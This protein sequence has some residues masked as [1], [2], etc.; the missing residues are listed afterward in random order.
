MERNFLR[1]G[2]ALVVLL[3][4]GS[5]LA[6]GPRGVRETAEASML[7]TGTVD[8]EPD[9]RVSGYRLDRVDELPPAVVDLVTK[10]AHIFRARPDGSGPLFPGEPRYPGPG[11]VLSPVQRPGV[12]QA[13]RLRPPRRAHTGQAGSRLNLMVCHCMD[14]ASRHSMR[15]TMGSPNWPKTL[16][17]SAACML[18]TIPTSGAR[19]PVVAQ[20]SSSTSSASGKR[21]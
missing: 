2:L 3:A 19:T 9:G 17:A 16:M 13:L 12:A 15:P 18:P 14:K 6:T 8:I 11:A 21:Q 4:A 20:R 10:A 7:V 1:W 5:V